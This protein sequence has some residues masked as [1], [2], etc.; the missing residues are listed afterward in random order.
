VIT[1]KSIIQVIITMEI[2]NVVS[3]QGQHYIQADFGGLYYNG[4]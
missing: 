4:T 3:G 2:S 1:E